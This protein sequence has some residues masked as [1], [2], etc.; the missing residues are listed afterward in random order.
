MNIIIA[1]RRSRSRGSPIRR[2]LRPLHAV[3]PAVNSVNTF[4]TDISFVCNCARTIDS[5]FSMPTYNCNRSITTCVTPASLAYRPRKRK[6]FLSLNSIYPYH[7]S[8]TES[9]IL[10]Q[11]RDDLGGSGGRFLTHIIAG[12]ANK[13][14]DDTKTAVLSLQSFFFLP[15]ARVTLACLFFP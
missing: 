2:R 15:F 6:R 11:E 3:A 8:K 4:S 10:R 13:T 14:I 9:R 7:T 12:K 1:Y 5:S